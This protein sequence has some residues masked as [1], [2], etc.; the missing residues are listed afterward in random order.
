MKERFGKRALTDGVYLSVCPSVSLSLSLC[1][2]NILKYKN[3]SKYR[4][5]KV[6]QSLTIT[7]NKLADSADQRSDCTFCAV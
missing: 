2:L 1:E 4:Y 5:F 6:V 3:Q 7:C